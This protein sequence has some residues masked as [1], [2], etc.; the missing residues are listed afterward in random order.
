MTVSKPTSGVREM[1]L[2]EVF[3]TDVEPLPIVVDLDRTLVT[4][5][6]FH[7]QFSQLLLLRPWLV[8]WAV[9]TWARGG[10]P[11]L[12][13]AVFDRS[14]FDL[15]HYRLNTALSDHLAQ[16]PPGQVIE[17]STGACASVAH[18]IAQRL[19]AISAVSWTHGRVN[20][21]GDRKATYLRHKYGVRGFY[22]I[23]DSAK[24]RKVGAVAAGL[25][26]VNPNGDRDRSA[27]RRAWR[28]FRDL[29]QEI[30]AKHWLKNLLVFVPIIASHEVASHPQALVHVAVL[31][32]AI[33]L[34]A[35]STYVLNDLIDYPNDVTNPLKSHRPL[36]AGAVS[37]PLATGTAALL[38]VTGVGLSLTLGWRGLASCLAYLVL[39]LSYM[40]LFKRMMLLDVIALSGLYVLRILIGGW[41]IGIELTSWL[42]LFALFIFFSLACVK[43]YTEIARLRVSGHDAVPGR[44]YQ[45]G[46]ARAVSLVGAS[47]GFAAILMYSLYV[48]S[49]AVRAMYVNPGV[50]ALGVPVLLYW[51][52]HL[53]LRGLRLEVNSDP[54]DW[55]A[56]DKR[57]I[58]AGLAF[59]LVY[60]GASIPLSIPSWIDQ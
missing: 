14:S 40:Y 23:G 25:V 45:L 24:D 54:I 52:S 47:S 28:T 1:T 22:Y 5:D 36:V 46:D 11:A 4:V 32:F 26:L 39:T 43:R 51:V 59:A 7:T 38:F 17:L 31:F 48:A 35:S 19:P 37:F 34:V 12:K 41:V 56:R 18:A 27:G 9:A 33:S 42:L 6:V 44:S 13:Q 15:A 49:D 2:N 16:V 55:A 3:G 20:L 29:I 8:F 30:R 53:W 10:L 58:G 60:L 57:S 21:T 50:L